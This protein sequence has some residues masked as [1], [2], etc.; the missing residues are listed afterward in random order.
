MGSCGVPWLGALGMQGSYLGAGTRHEPA[1]FS[2]ASRQMDER[3]FSWSDV[4][5]WYFGKAITFGLMLK[6]KEKWLGSSVPGMMCWRSWD[7][8]LLP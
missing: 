3:A 8:T 2:L 1:E 4:V 5:V 7:T 6:C